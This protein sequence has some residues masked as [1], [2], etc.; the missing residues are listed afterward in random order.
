MLTTVRQLIGR[1]GNDIWSTQPNVM[2]FEALEMMADKGIGSLL[3]YDGDQLAGIFS[4]RD[5]ARKVIL[6]GKSSH[7]TQVHE[8]MTKNVVCVR[9]DQTMT[10]C[11]AL[12]TNKR[13]R[14][15]PVLAENKVVGVISI[16]DVVK[17]IISEQEFVIGQ[18]ENY[19]TGGR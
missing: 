12:M 8:I 7:D 17:E 13:I 15:L 11:M 4:E 14:H 10:D 6:K 5:Y 19:I 3:V 18:L 16:G 1:K 9:P 2:I